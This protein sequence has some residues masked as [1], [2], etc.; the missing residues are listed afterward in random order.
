MIQKNGTYIQGNLAEKLEYNA[1]EENKV[2]RQKKK[3]RSGALPKVK[4]V[5]FMLVIFATCF[6][7]VYRYAVITEL[8]FQ[9]SKAEKQ[10]NEIRNENA[11][12]L[13]EIKKDTD[14]NTIQQIAETRLGMQKPDKSQIV[15]MNVPKNDYTVVAESYIQD[16]DTNEGVFASL[17][18]KI[19]RIASFLY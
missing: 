11:R 10:Y 3:A 1:Y 13:V 18:D 8:N 19:G 7:I 14:L 4:T 15:Y 2:L 12:L 9:I 5:A 16:K 6:L 17:I